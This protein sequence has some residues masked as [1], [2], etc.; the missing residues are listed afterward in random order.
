MR[1]CLCNLYHMVAHIT[2]KP[3][4]G[5]HT[6]ILTNQVSKSATKMGPRVLGG[7]KQ[8]CT[9]LCERE[10]GHF[11]ASG[12]NK[13]ENQ[14]VWGLRQHYAQFHEGRKKYVRVQLLSCVGLFVTPWTV[15]HQALLSR[16]FPRQEYRSGLPC[17]PPGDLS[18]PGI[19]PVSP[20]LAGR[21]FITNAIWEAQKEVLC[22]SKVR[23]WTRFPL[24]P[25][26]G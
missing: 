10:V 16:G 22:W 6:W 20:S 2:S 11:F 5:K 7:R 3:L 23:F 21:F 8:G 14:R 13:W 19:E 9:G 4:P 26:G 24:R 12:G 15:A 17:P 1:V 25:L 18:N